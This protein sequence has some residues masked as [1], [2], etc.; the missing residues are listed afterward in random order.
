MGR[1]FLILL[2]FLPNL[3]FA[4]YQFQFKNDVPLTI[5]EVTSGLRWAGG[6]NS[7]QFQKLD[8]NADGIE[9]LVI[10]HRMSKQ[11]TTFLT[12]NKEYIFSPDFAALL[13][14]E[15]NEY[16]I[17]K[18]F[19]CDGLKDIFTSTPFGIKVFKNITAGTTL[20]WELAAEVLQFGTGIN[21]QVNSED[22]PG[23]EDIDGD[24]DLDILTYRFTNSS[25]IDYYRNTSIENTSACGQLTFIRDSRV[26][27][28]FEECSCNDIVFG[29]RCIPGGIVN[30]DI[31]ELGIEGIEHAGGKTILPIDLDNDGD[32]DLISSDESCET[33][34][35]ME[36]VGD[37]RTARMTA[38]SSFPASDPA[39]FYIFPSA[40]FDDFDF[41]GIKDLVISSNAGENALNGIDFAQNTSIYKNT[42]SNTNII[43]TSATPFLQDKMLDIGETTYPALVDFDADGDLDLFVG[44][45]GLIETSG[46]IASI[47]LFENNGTQFEPSFLQTNTDYLN[48]KSSLYR[49]I[50]PQFVDLDG[51][52]DLDLTYQATTA[53][54]QTSILYRI[55][56]AGSNNPLML[57]NEKTM[58]S[59]QDESDQPFFYDINRDGNV[60]LLIGKRLGALHLLENEGNF[61]FIETT[62]AYAGISDNFDKRNLVPAITDIDNDGR[63]ELITTD[64]SGQI[65]IHSGNL[66]SSFIPDSVNTEM[67]NNQYF[68]EFITSNNGLISPFVTGDLL[69]TGK[70][71]FIQGNNRGGLHLL[72]NLSERGLNS[73]TQPIVLNLFP[74]PSNLQFMVRTDVTATI[75]IYS[76]TGQLINSGVSITGNTNLEFNSTGMAPGIYLIRAYNGSNKPTVKRLLI[77]R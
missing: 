61:N 16:L 77:L 58:L 20:Q 69:G 74:N 25:T 72:E 37:N 33:L 26:W 52:G 36:N 47:F 34:Y 76:A 41:D 11:V 38:F 35:Y 64:Y 66:G 3:V 49:N 24:G 10:Y 62:I 23:I 6:L 68:E 27:G 28:D 60:D 75:D 43:F 56:T 50:K 31:I 54:G 29:T 46:F 44:N 48:L 15:I 14:E 5:D 30:N 19:D 17:I 59:S 4:Q 71:I 13:P 51:D 63:P 18:D 53:N 45:R 32:M 8:L 7:G 65:R 2:F 1:H 39:A 40:F 9:D 12:V 73:A 70:P 67:I 21:I 22:I 55:N 42:G 57:G